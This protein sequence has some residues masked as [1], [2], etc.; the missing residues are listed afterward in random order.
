MLVVQYRIAVGVHNNKAADTATF[1]QTNLCWLQSFGYQVTMYIAH[2][3]ER[4]HFTG[5]LIPT[6]VERQHVVIKHALKYPNKMIAVLE[7]QIVVIG[8]P[9]KRLEPQLFI[10]KAAMLQG[11]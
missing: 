7:N 4:I 8:V 10:K 9:T 11:F 3:C 5:V 1:G 6:G 2:I